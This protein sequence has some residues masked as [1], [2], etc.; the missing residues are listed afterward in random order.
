[1]RI[2]EILE[3]LMMVTT[4]RCLSVPAN[5]WLLGKTL[6]MTEGMGLTLDP[7]FDIF[8]VSE[9]FVRELGWQMWLPNREWGQILLRW[10][11]EWAEFV[12]LLPRLGRRLLE[13]VER[14]EPLEFELK[15]MGR[16]LNELGRLVNRLSL[17]IVIAGLVVSLAILIA[18]TAASSA[19][20]SRSIVQKVVGADRRCPT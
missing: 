5:L 16:M 20:F 4:R 6:A 14:N 10:G 7:D 12:N 19:K 2:Q 13:K 18:V 1:M 3:E 17:S 11:A 9:P 15:D 8:A